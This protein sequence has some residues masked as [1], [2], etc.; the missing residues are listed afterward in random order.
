[1]MQ[2]TMLNKTNVAKL[3]TEIRALIE[4][5]RQSFVTIFAERIE[6]QIANF[7]AN[8]KPSQTLEEFYRSYGMPE[9]VRE[10]LVMDP[11]AVRD[12]RLWG[13]RPEDRPAFS[14]H[15]HEQAD[16]IIRSISERN[17]NDV[18]AAFI[19]RAL[20]KLSPVVERKGDFTVAKTTDHF[21]KFERATGYWEGVLSLV[22]EDGTKFSATLTII[23]NF[24]KF[25]KPF[26]QYPMRFFDC[27]LVPGADGFGAAS[28]EEI[29]ASVGYVPAP[30]AKKSRWSKVISGSVLLANGTYHLVS[31][32]GKLKKLGLTDY[33]QVARIGDQTW[34]GRVEYQDGTAKRYSF[35]EDEKAQLEALEKAYHFNWALTKRREFIFQALFGE[36][37]I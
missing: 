18:L 33:E 36:G 13:K 4:P 16:A 1:M 29:W 17:A 30:P 23:T 10:S 14:Y 5:E 31:S 32:P 21:S 24:S 35:T 9:G 19:S 27:V 28:I 25:G 8:R 3:E 11:E 22:F 12:R 15:R 7:L 6:R 26:G 34:G 20:H 37:V 2:T